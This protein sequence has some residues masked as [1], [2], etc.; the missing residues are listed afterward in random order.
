VAE[1]IIQLIEA[2]PRVTAIQKQ[3]D[4]SAATYDRLAHGARPSDRDKILAE[5]R[6]FPVLFGYKALYGRALP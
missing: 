1:G 6:N 2:D 5:L 3:F 4:E